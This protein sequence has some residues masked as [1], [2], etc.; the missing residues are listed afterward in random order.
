[1]KIVKKTVLRWLNRRGFQVGKGIGR[2]SKIN[3]STKAKIRSELKDKI[4]ASV[5]KCA[6]K[7][8]L[9]FENVGRDKSFSKPR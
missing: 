8:N 1:M 9:L 3:P 5:R 7:L 6:K 4:E 2:K